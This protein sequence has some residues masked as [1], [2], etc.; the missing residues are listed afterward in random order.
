MP[1]PFLGQVRIDFGWKTIPVGY[2]QSCFFI[3]RQWD[4][5]I[6]RHCND[7]I[8]YTYINS[9]YPFSW[10]CSNIIS[11]KIWEN[12]NIYYICIIKLTCMDGL[13]FQLWHNCVF[14]RNSIYYNIN[15][16]IQFCYDVQMP[17]NILS[18]LQIWTE[19][20]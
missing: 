10:M 4:Y 16:L 11:G 9:W 12:L 20:K 1:K 17:F 5:K 6:M 14:F 3:T 19:S 15:L 7:N 2:T 8:N 13:N 18:D